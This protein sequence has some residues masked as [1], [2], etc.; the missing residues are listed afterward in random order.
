M[1]Y[2]TGF[3]KI[4]DAQGRSLHGGDAQWSL[5]TDDK[6]GSWMERVTPQ[7]CETGYH[8]TTDPLRWWRPGSRLF[9]AEGRGKFD[10]RSTDQKVAVA[11]ARLLSEVTSAWSW[12][13]LF[14]RAQ[15]FT[16]LGRGACLRS[17]NFAN[18]Y[19][20][21]VDLHGAILTA[22][23]FSQAVLDN[24][25]LRKANLDGCRLDMASLECSNL[26]G[27]S[28]QYADICGANF[29]MADL[30]GADLTHVRGS[31]FFRRAD[32][33]GAKISTGNLELCAKLTS[34]GWYLR[35][36]VGGVRTVGKNRKRWAS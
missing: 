22:S 17:A 32:M 31:A 4:L 21:G 6:P 11:Q 12:G 33:E 5:P 28:F 13:L 1:V 35:K 14:P 29:A 15:L 30:C 2:P 16:R 23:S 20:H 10:L 26:A 24:A 7:C 8:L 3:F 19:L 34:L 36:D 18:A 25:D 27:A 9:V